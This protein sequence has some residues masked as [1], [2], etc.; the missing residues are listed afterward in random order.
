[1][2]CSVKRFRV[3]IFTNLYIKNIIEFRRKDGFFMN[4]TEKMFY[5]W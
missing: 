1:L 2:S 3:G 5:L 4:K